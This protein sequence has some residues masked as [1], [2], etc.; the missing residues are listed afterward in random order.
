MGIK[1]I[2]VDVLN[3]L[4]SHTV[5]TIFHV[6]TSVSIRFNVQKIMDIE[7]IC[8]MYM[9][10]MVAPLFCLN[11]CQNTRSSH[12]FLSGAGELHLAPAELADE[13]LG[14]IKS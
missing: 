13:E 4:S 3:D 10:F 2:Y 9:I 8:M 11:T 7:G 1:W 6:F 5:F 12:L 14:V